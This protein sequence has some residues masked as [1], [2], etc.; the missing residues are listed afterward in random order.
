[1]KFHLSSD[2]WIS[3]SG[4]GVLL[5]KTNSD[6]SV[7]FAVQLTM[8]SFYSA[9]ATVTGKDFQKTKEFF[10]SAEGGI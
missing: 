10:E 9:V 3:K 5:E 1:M 2:V 8:E 4:N 7:G 6:E